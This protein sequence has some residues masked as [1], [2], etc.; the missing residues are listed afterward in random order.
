MNVAGDAVFV[1]VPSTQIADCDEVK[2]A[3]F[4]VQD[5]YGPWSSGSTFSTC[6]ILNMY[7]NYILDE[8]K[9]NVHKIY[10]NSVSF[11]FEVI[12]IVYLWGINSFTIFF[13][14]FTVLY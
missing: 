12:T 7:I 9:Y 1:Q 6:I 14:V 4:E 8:D 13:V 11:F 3:N 10:L 5:S 2:V